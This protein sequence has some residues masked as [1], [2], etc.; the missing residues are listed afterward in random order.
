[1]FARLINKYRSEPE[2]HNMLS[3]KEYLQKETGYCAFWVNEILEYM[4]KI[5]F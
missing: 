3:V 4:K 5:R 1:M 2:N